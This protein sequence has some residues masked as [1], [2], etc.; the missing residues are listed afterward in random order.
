MPAAS[1]TTLTGYGQ[2]R[3]GGGG[4]RGEGGRGQEGEGEAGSYLLD[5]SCQLLLRPLRIIWVNQ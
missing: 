5:V 1:F 2:E 3:G 4:R